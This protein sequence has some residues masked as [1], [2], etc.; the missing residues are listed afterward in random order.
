MGPQ[1]IF[2]ATHGGLLAFVGV[3]VLVI[4]TPGPDTA[5]TVR[6]T[7]LG[8]WRAGFATAIGVVSGQ[9][10]W[11][12]GTSIGVVGLLLASEPVFN[13]VKLLGAAYL[14]FLGV[15]S[16]RAAF[17]RVP[18]WEPAPDQTA[19]HRLLLGRAFRQGIV[20]DLGNPK[21]AAFFTS[22]LPQFLPSPNVLFATTMTLGLL[23]CLM[24]LGW[25]M[26]YVT[27]VARVGELLRRT[28][29]R[30]ALEG[31][32]GAVLVGLGIRLASEHR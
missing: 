20:N 3:A 1:G 11:A 32:T 28:Q 18:P 13:A 16:I 5:L 7:L 14:V 2:S 31:L 21:M 8:G 19:R 24:T 29:I 25:L 22:L 15:Q 10:I 30:R 26:I 6:N 12:F 27:V 9:A 17:A 23:F 4:V